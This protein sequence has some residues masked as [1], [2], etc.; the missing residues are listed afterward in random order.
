MHYT[1]LLHNMLDEVPL[2]KLP[3]IELEQV[4]TTRLG[5][6]WTFGIV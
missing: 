3:G 6:I 4:D 1:T 2:M 5:S